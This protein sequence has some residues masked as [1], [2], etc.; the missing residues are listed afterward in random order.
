MKTSSLFAALI[1]SVLALLVPQATAM[2]LDVRQFGAK[3]D[4][5]TPDRDSINKAI[6][7]AAEKGGGTVEVPAGT[8]LTGSIH[9]RS[10]I[11]LHLEAGAVLLASAEAALYDAAEPNSS[12]K[13]QD[14]GHSHWRN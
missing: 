5:K 1:C 4:G 11:T 2:S 9:L 7:A 6:D 12:N 13:F 3:G 10:N 14:F 8:Y